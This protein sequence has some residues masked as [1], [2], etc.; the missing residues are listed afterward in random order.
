MMVFVIY[1]ILYILFILIDIIPLYNDGD[2]KLFW[3]Y[4]ILFL[5]SYVFFA[6]ISA[7]IKI[8]SP[9]DAI[10]KIIMRIINFF[11]LG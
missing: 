1:S 2:K 5:C 3:I 9:A 6:L 11:Y 8:P 7:G 10:E 4:T